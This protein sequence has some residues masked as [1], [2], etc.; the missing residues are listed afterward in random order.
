MS[1]I[2][3]FKYLQSRSDPNQTGDGLCE[4]IIQGFH[5]LDEAKPG[6]QK[7][8]VHLDDLHGLHH[9][10]LPDDVLNT[11]LGPLILPSAEVVG[12]LL[13]GFHG[14]LRLLLLQKLQTVDRE[15]QVGF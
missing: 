12:N 6:E 11:D 2:I 3:F 7:V 8:A 13:P 1:S 15:T 10:V 5:L 14:H 4:T 9:V